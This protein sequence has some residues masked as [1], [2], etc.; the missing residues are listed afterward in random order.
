MMQKRN[1]NSSHTY[2]GGSGCAHGPGEPWPAFPPCPS[3]REGYTCSTLLL[4][5]G[6]R[7]LINLIEG[8]GLSY[9]TGQN[10]G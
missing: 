9:V 3:R 6:D 5:D 8:G 2:G 4:N 10:S 1:G 7:V